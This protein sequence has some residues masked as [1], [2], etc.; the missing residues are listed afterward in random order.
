MVEQTNE[1]WDL[2]MSKKYLL[3][4]NLVAGINPFVVLV[5]VLMAFVM[6][7]RNS[8]CSSDGDQDHHEDEQAPNGHPVAS[9]KTLLVCGDVHLMLV[10]F[11]LQ[12]KKY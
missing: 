9:S 5:L 11:L 12:E 8:E 6:N 1:F 3:V 10:H 4:S 2:V 7:E